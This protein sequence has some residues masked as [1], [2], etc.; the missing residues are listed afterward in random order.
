ML[1]LISINILGIF[2]FDTHRFFLDPSG[3]TGRNVIIFG[4]DIN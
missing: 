3:G 4:V 1:I 2:G